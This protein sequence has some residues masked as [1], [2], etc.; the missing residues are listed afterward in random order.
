MIDLN[1]LKTFLLTLN[2][3]GYATGEQKQWIKEKD[4][5]TTIPFTQG[6]WS[7]HD[8]FF[9]G[10][11][12]GGRLVV[13]YEA[14]PVWI[15]VYYGSITPSAD[16]N[17][18]YAVLREALKNMPPDAPFRGPRELSLENG[19]YIYKNSWTGTVEQYSGEETIISGEETV[20]WA[21]YRGGLVD[22]RKGV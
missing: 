11:P 21:H 3:A 13:S 2:A 10:E 6:K 7:S 15:M 5:S 20:Y 12:Y 14:K 8:N 18:I 1:A 4:G 19:R 17:P 22:Q 16:V 9:G